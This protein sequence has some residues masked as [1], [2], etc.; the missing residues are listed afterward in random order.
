[1]TMYISIHRIKCRSVILNKGQ[2]SIGQYHCLNDMYLLWINDWRLRALKTCKW[3]SFLTVY[4]M[5]IIARRYSQ[6]NESTDLYTCESLHRS[7]YVEEKAANINSIHGKTVQCKTR[8]QYCS[9]I[10]SNIQIQNE[11]GINHSVMNCFSSNTSSS[12]LIFFMMN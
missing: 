10:N 4:S 2:C 8:T 3:N 7:V 9:F 1:M 11:I 12:N 5:F 6:S